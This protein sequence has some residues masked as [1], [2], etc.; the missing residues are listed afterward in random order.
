MSETTRVAS[1]DTSKTWKRAVGVAVVLVGSVFV[2]IALGM[3]ILALAPITVAVILFGAI[4]TAWR[5]YAVRHG[6][7]P[8]KLGAAHLVGGAASRR[9]HR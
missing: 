2:A 3:S 8:R 9:D 1:S 6:D 5:Y 7:E 4:Y